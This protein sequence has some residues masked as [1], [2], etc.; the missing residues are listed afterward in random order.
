[1]SNVKILLVDDH[2]QNLI[3]LEAILSGLASLV[4][5]TSG[6]E[7]LRELLRT[8]FAV[9]LLDVQMP[10]MDGFETAELI[11][12]RVKLEH[13]P[14]I[15]L[16]ARDKDDKNVF[17]GY[18]VGAVD[19]ITKPF[20]A[21]V[22]KAKVSVFIDL[23]KKTEEIKRQSELLREANN[24]LGK[25]NKAIGG[26]YSQLEHKNLEL[27]K[28]RDF[29]SAVI[30]TAGSFVVVLDIEGRIERFNRACQE[31]GGYTLEEV[32][33]KHV[34]DVLVKP[35]DREKVKRVFQT[36][37]NS[38]VKSR[39]QVPAARSFVSLNGIAKPIK[40]VIADEV[41]ELNDALHS[42]LPLEPV[43]K[44]WSWITRTG[45]VRHI[46]WSYTALVDELHS[47]NY[48][49]G[50]GIDITARH[51]AETS[52]KELNEDLER[53][54]LTRTAQLQE[55]NVELESEVTERKRAETELSR[56]KDA[57]EQANRAKDQFLAVLSHE[58]R[59]PLTPVLTIVQMLQED[60]AV[61]EETG[62]WLQSIRRNVELEAR[63]IDDLLDLTR[64]SKGKL[65]L[66]FDLVGVHGLI[67]EVLDICRKDINTKKLSLITELNA[68][69]DCVHADPARLQQVLWNLIKNAVK[70]TP[71]G[72]K[73]CVRTNGQENDIQIQV[74]DTGIG[75]NPQML[76]LIFDA[77][78]QGD[79]SITREFG[80]LGLGLAISK[81]LVEAHHGT[82]KVESDGKNK[83]ATFSLKL[84]VVEPLE[85][86]SKQTPDDGAVVVR[87]GLH[88]LVVEDN[89]DTSTA[90]KLLL[91]RHGY[92]VEVAHSVR[93]A[94][95]L[96][97]QIKFDAVVS[98]IG[99][100][101]GTGL[102]LIRALRDIRVV[103]AVALSGFG[104]EQ[105]VE[106][107][108]EAG[109]LAHLTKPV[110]FD[111]LDETLQRVTASVETVSAHT[112]A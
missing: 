80:G 13:T 45:N 67:K 95:T 9:I 71:E 63:L 46:S 90:M 76:P 59:T 21:D 17:K 93:S 74:T 94:I 112:A 3:A 37:R 81:A 49:I 41:P 102:E 24:E 88:V 29:I 68:S 19:Y 66:N 36:V 40:Q 10:G 64:I 1:M 106:K 108:I 72:G 62:V 110:N 51:Q 55:A 25:T 78:E 69:N 65:Q 61:S 89:E 103:P 101:D 50:T 27:H 57:A 70:F 14:I 38:G 4:K 92:R 111:Q 32:H 83:G 44:E 79:K 100:P 16:T 15:F 60:P 31:T 7:A 2:P 54:V 96:F 18:S 109:F 33:G 91:Q 85:T 86:M 52:L 22:L 104:M 77:F 107:S 97:K 48:I 8:D 5:V 105:D 84:A 98:D 30:E 34:W 6:R 11:R 20:S 58:L 39:L 56:A 53:R 43:C 99:L 82:I 73:I 75:I 47:V 26:L 12:E 28:E 23:F 87:E 42:V 35:E